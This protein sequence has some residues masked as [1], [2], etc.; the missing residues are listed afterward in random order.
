LI[1]QFGQAE[2]LA[3]S[4]EFLNRELVANRIRGETAPDAVCQ[5][6]LNS[7]ARKPQ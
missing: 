1:F 3:S 7:P 4:V 2:V 6:D 5:G